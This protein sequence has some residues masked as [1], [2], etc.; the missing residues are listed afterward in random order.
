MAETIF[1][2]KHVK[3]LTL[4]QIFSFFRP[5]YT[6]RTGF[7]EEFFVGDRPGDTGNGYSEEEQVGY[8]GK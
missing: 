5:A 7:P 1:T 8:G 2:G 3:E 6:V 4:K